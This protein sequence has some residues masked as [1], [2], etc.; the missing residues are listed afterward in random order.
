MKQLL[1]IV[2]G[3]LVWLGVAQPASA[4]ENYQGDHITNVTLVSDGIYIML[5]RGLPTNCA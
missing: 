2:F 4:A 1:S 5:D 3:M